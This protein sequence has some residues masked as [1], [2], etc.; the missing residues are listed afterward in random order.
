MIHSIYSI[1]QHYLEDA[2][3]HINLLLENFECLFFLT[4]EFDE[5]DINT[6]KVNYEQVHNVNKMEGQQEVKKVWSPEEMFAEVY[7]GSLPDLANG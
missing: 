1:E 7:G 6:S 2:N 4:L 3:S 5:D